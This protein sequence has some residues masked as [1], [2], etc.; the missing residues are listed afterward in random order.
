MTEDPVAALAAADE[1]YRERQA[2]VDEVGESALQTV[3]TAHEELTALLDRSEETATGTGEFEAFL[4]F[5]GRVA[6][7]VEDLPADLPRREAFEDVSEVLHARTLRHKH[8]ARAREHLSAVEP[9]VER[10]E[11]RDDAL[12]AYREARRDAVERREEA[13]ARVERLES[14]VAYADVDWD[15]PVEVLQRPVAAYNDAVDAAVGS[16][17]SAASA[18]A[19]LRWVDTVA[20]AYPLAGL[21]APPRDV[22]DYLDRAA[23]GEEP[24]PTVLEYADYSRSKLDHYV[25]DPGRFLAVVGGSETA[26]ARDVADALAVAWPPPPAASLRFRCDELVAA[27]GRLAEAPA[28]RCREVRALTRRADYDRLRATAAAED[29]LDAAARERV[30]SGEA[31]TSL[32]AARRTLAGLDRALATHP[33]R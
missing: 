14:L 33:E 31:A 6:T 12:A 1:R 23:V 11:R 2:A 22:V 5:Q 8:F 27:T 18:R 10:L 17:R 16:F 4:E 29:A 28:A 30:A 7:L 13:A 9:L 15:A 26:L 20:R 21:D 32:A 25:D 24:L 19:F 3:A